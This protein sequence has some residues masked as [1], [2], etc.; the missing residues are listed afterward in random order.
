[1]LTFAKALAGEHLEYFLDWL[2]YPIQTGEKTEVA[3]VVL[4]ATGGVKASHFAR[5]SE[6]Y[7]VYL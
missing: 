2:A 4:G 6:A 1:M 3:L 5:G 7:F